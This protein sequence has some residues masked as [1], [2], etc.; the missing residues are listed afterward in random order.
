MRPWICLR[1]ARQEARSDYRAGTRRSYVGH[2]R[3]IGFE[4]LLIVLIERHTPCRIAG[5][6][7]RL[8]QLIGQLIVVR[9]QARIDAAERDDAGAG[10]GRD[11][12]HR[13]RFEPLAVC[14]SI[15]QNQAAF[16]I[17]V[18]NLNRLP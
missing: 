14:K 2:V 4:L 17:G 18:Q 6:V 9:E 7:A 16:G 3:K 1:K 11:I 13:R 12:N 5:L 10:E 15:T 8:E